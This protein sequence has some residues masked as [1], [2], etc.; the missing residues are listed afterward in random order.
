MREGRQCSSVQMQA[1]W[2]CRGEGTLVRRLLALRH[3]PLLKA[4]LPLVLRS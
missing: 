4:A 2:M 3:I 1:V